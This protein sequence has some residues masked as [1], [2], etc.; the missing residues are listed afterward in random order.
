MLIKNLELIFKKNVKPV[1]FQVLHKAVWF[2]ATARNAIIGNFLNDQFKIQKL[3]PF[4]F[5]S[6][7]FCLLLAATMDPDCPSHPKEVDRPPGHRAT[8]YLPLDCG[9]IPNVKPCTCQINPNPIEAQP[10]NLR[11]KAGSFACSH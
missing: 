1:F 4:D 9:S 5:C 7:I 2:A 10:P 3:K 6:V 11:R 8:T